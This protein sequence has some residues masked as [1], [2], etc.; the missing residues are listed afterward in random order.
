MPEAQTPRVGSSTWQPEHL[1]Q[2]ADEQGR[3]LEVVSATEVVQQVAQRAMELL[4]LRPGA[5]VLEVGCGSGVF[6]P[7]LAQAVGPGGQVLG[8]DHSADLIAQAR[9]RVREAGLDGVV[10]L[11]VGDAYRLPCADA[12]FD[13]AHCERVLMHLDDPNAALAEMAR[14]LKPG[15]VL[16]A[17]EPDWA[18]M[19]IDHPDRPVFDLVFQRALKHRNPDMGLTLFRRLGEFGLVQLRH[20]N[21]SVVVEDLKTWAMFGLDLPPA[22]E[23]LR[24]SGELP[25][26]RLDAVLPALERADAAGHF[27][28]AAT[29]HVIAGHKAER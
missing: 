19:R 25:A 11:E 13:A 20:A 26:A 15:G 1:K 3:Y 21:V 10:T 7:R 4:A 22:V 17:A 12:S 29:L 9:A 28:S 27:Y 2:H 16:V 24:V 6:L 5:R 14:V 18:G 23:A 8:I